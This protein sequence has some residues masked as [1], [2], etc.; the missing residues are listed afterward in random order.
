MSD[1]LQSLPF[2]IDSLHAAYRDGLNPA[3]V[4]DEVMARLERAADPGIFIALHDRDALAAQSHALGAFDPARPLW[5]VPFAVKDNIDVA[6]LATTAACPAFAYRPETDAAVVAALRS[7]GAIV[8]G[9]T[10]LDQFATGLVGMRS[11]Y[12]PPRNALDP[13]LVPGGSSSGSAVAVAHGIVSFALGTDTA[14]S[15]RVPAALNNLVGLK[16]TLGLLSSRGLVPACRTLDTISIFACNVRD[17][18][19]ALQAAA[20]YDD[21]DPFSRSLPAPRMATPDFAPRIGVPD[22]ASLRL[23]AP[24][25]AAAFEVALRVLEAQ[26]ASLVEID[27]AP[28]FE[29]AALLYHGAWVA[30]RH[31]VV[32]PL[33]ERDPDALHPVTRRIVERARTLSAT[34]AFRDRYRLQA[35]IRAC[36]RAMAGIDLLCVPSIPGPLTVASYEADPVASND[37][38]GTYTNFVNLLDLC[39][40]AVPVQTRAAA[41]PPASVTLLARAGQDG[42]AATVAAGLTDA[43]AGPPGA[44]AWPTRATGRPAAVAAHASAPEA[45]RDEVEAGPGELALAVVGAHMSG[46]PLNGELTARGARLLRRT[47]TAP[48]YRLYALAGGPQA[49]PGLVRDAAGAAIDL[50]VWAMPVAEVGTF[51]AGIPSPLGLGTLR[52]RDGTHVH[53][54]IC[55]PCGLLGAREVTAHGGWRAYLAHAAASRT[56]S[57][58]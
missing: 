21:A 35:L 32:Q 57:P 33:L 52:L 50:E 22:V 45:G 7:A 38:L 34:D 27:L 15:G 12:P 14:G 51:L 25:S 29:V 30:E 40:I 56:P 17:A 42:L 31:A 58:R 53:G 3:R 5:G 26:G 10:N 36:N 49:R 20:G 9:K 13:A 18:V 44:T 2:D 41:N 54:F 8:I 47:Q 16:P 6:G 48:E 39:G 1:G 28:F 19:C 55:E 43:L 46:M 4:I 24:S 23:D 37:R 11:P